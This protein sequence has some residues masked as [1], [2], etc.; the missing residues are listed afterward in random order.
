LRSTTF[1][2]FSAHDSVQSIENFNF[3]VVSG[4][5]ASI[6]SVMTFSLTFS[7]MLNISRGCD[8]KRNFKCFC[9]FSIQTYHFQSW[10]FIV[11]VD[12]F[13]SDLSKSCMRWFTHCLKRISCLNLNENFSLSL[14]I[15]SIINQSFQFTRFL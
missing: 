2:G 13:N 9:S 8:F 5:N 4:S 15:K 11:H 14:I 1:P 10:C 12:N 3:A 6:C 7:R